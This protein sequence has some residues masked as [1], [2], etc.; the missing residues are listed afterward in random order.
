VLTI[1]ETG[2]CTKRE[3]KAT[4]FNNEFVAQAPLPVLRGRQRH[5][6]GRL[7][8]SLSGGIQEVS[9]LSGSVFRNCHPEPLWAK[10]LPR[11]FGLEGR[12][13]AFQRKS[14]WKSHESAIRFQSF[15]GGPSPKAA[16][17]DSSYGMLWHR[18]P[19]L[20]FVTAKDTAEGG[21]ATGCF[22]VERGYAYE[23]TDPAIATRLF[24]SMR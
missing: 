5:S 17:D 22:F 15:A 2:D 24:A 20:C 11:Y 12:I 1:S 21:C 6:R 13:L 19:R 18:H 8:H 7:C 3:L 14:S 10:D 4:N 23:V 16:Q 9:L